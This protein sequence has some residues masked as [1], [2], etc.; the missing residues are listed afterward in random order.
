MNKGMSLSN[1]QLIKFKDE[2]MKNINCNE[3]SLLIYFIFFLLSLNVSIQKKDNKYILS[4]PNGLTIDINKAADSVKN[5]NNQLPGGSLI[6]YILYIVT[7]IKNSLVKDGL[8]RL[9]A[10]IILI[11]LSFFVLCLVSFIILI[12]SNVINL[13]LGIALIMVS[14][15]V[16]GVFLILTLN[17]FKVLTVNLS[18]DINEI[19]NVESV[20]NNINCA[21]KC[22]L[23][24]YIDSSCECKCLNV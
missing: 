3:L 15:V 2:L 17:E 24:S 13:T 4:I 1:D 23:A 20:V 8:K 18:R 11:F 22:S 10:I 5:F 12:F 21:L 7:N 14:F 9:E 6:N 16:L 19:T